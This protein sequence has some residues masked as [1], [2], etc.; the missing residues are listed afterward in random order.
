MQN[1][2][3]AVECSVCGKCVG[4]HKTVI[5][6]NNATRTCV[7]CSPPDILDEPVI[8]CSTANT[9]PWIEAIGYVHFDL[10]LGQVLDVLYPPLPLSVAQ[11]T[12]VSF[13]CFPDANHVADGDS[14]QSPAFCEQTCA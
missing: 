1:V 3:D 14:I 13:L 12:E 10:L 6:T 9:P 5:C 2:F 11:E 8:Y 7:G 4:I